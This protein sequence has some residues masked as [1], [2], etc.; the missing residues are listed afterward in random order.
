[1][2]RFLRSALALGAWLAATH[3]VAQPGTLEGGW[4]MDVRGPWEGLEPTEAAEQAIAEFDR[5]VDDPSMRCIAPG[6]IRTAES[7]APVEIV[8]QDHQILF[9]HES[10]N[11]VRRI[12]TSGREAPEWTPASPLG[13]S[14]GT[15]QGDELVV[16]TT[17]LT[18]HLF[19][20]A[21][22]PF[23]G[24]PQTRIVERYRGTGDRLTIEFTVEDPV[25]LRAP[26]TRT[27][28]YDRVPDQVLL[29]FHCDPLDATGWRLPATGD[30]ERDLRQ[31]R[32]LRPLI[33]E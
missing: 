13:Y 3:A 29:H 11:V 26:T 21:G 25:N 1:M 4:I 12:L 5:A 8:E 18:P 28:T 2:T 17:H 15:W 23:S 14:V 19:N 20:D 33:P 9:L 22:F 16:E 30:S 24:G 6:L 10:F 7:R 27:L 32:D 31:W